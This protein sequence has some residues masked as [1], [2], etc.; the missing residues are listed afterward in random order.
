M[1]SLPIVTIPYELFGL[2]DE[3]IEKTAETLVGDVVAALITPRERLIEEFR[4]KQGVEQVESKLSRPR[5][6]DAYEPVR[7]PASL[8]EAIDV[9]YQRG[10]TDG[11]PIVPPTEAAVEDMLA[12]T[13]RGPD[14]VVGK[15]PPRWGKATVEKVAVNAVMAGCLP[16]YFPVVLAA[17]EALA[18]PSFNLFAL[19]ATTNP[20]AP[21]AIVNG[22]VV[23]ELGIN[24]S[25]N[26]FGPGWRPNATIGRAIRLIMTNIG[27]GIPGTTDKAI[28]GQ[29]AKYTFCIAEN[30]QENPWE[31]LSVERGFDAQVSTVTLVGAQAVHNFVSWASTPGSILST[32]LNGM[33]AMGTNNLFHAGTA[34]IA[35]NPGHAA[36]LARDG[37]SKEGVKR[38]LFDNV[39]APMSKLHP[40]E[41]PH[42]QLR[43]PHLNW[44]VTDGLISVADKWEDIMV[45]VVGAAG[46]HN[47]FMPTFGDPTVPVTRAIAF[48][49][50]TPVKSV[51][52]LRRRR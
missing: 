5:A 16:Q 29:P 25:F 32:I 30:E 20:V 46:V 15:I 4:N 48:K 35:M 38:F 49:D 41:V 45:V 9:F 7:A 22:P 52:E 13:D 34:V 39:R 17:T 21:L 10:W 31:P 26:A 18:E 8:A 51:E 42:Y 28:Q 12:Y 33:S 27:G 1:P 50:G 3:E 44:Q 24:F 11:L 23:K 43:R 19:Q 47:I 14:D 36:I 40:D 6:T 2:T 37:Y